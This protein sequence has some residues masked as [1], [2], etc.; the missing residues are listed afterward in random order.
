[1]HAHIIMSFLLTSSISISIN[2][3][4]NISNF[5]KSV[6]PWSETILTENSKRSNKSWQN[7]TSK[8]LRENSKLV[9]YNEVIP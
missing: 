2:L 5:N 6:R 9:D 1:M 7:D 8:S 4:G 3:C